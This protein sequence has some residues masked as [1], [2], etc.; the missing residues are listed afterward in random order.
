MIPEPWWTREHQMGRSAGRGFGLDFASHTKTVLGR[1]SV[2][3]FPKV[4]NIQTLSVICVQEDNTEL[5]YLK[6][7]A[8]L[9]SF[10]YRVNLPYLQEL[11]N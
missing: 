1:S 6:A 2:I 3:H 7:K 4:Q 9:I 11:I 5:T 8:S 10:W